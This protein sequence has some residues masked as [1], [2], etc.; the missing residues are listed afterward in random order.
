MELDKV[1]RILHLGLA[2]FGVWTWW[3]GEDASDYKS[4]NH[5]TSMF[6]CLLTESE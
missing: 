4:M 1:T 3:T 6:G 2:V 5:K